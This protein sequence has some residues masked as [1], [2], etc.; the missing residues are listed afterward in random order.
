MGKKINSYRDLEVWQRAVQLSVWACRLVRTAAFPRDEQYG[1]SLQMRR[2][3]VSVPSNIA[4]GQARQTTKEFPHFLHIAKGSLA[5][6]D[7]QSLIALDLQYL[8]TKDREELLEQID[9]LQRM[10]Y[11]LIKRL[12]QKG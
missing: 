3:S 7:T 2:C 12:Q 4:E 10:L 1:L 5:E 6:L 9:A 8:K 11:A